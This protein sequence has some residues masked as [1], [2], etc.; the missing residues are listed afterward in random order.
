MNWSA[1]FNGFIPRAGRSAPVLPGGLSRTVHRVCNV[2]GPPGRGD[3]SLW[4]AEMAALAVYAAETPMSQSVVQT[5]AGDG[6]P[7]AALAAGTA[8][9]RRPAIWTLGSFSTAADA[10]SA[11]TPLFGALAA[12]GFGRQV[13]PVTASPVAAAQAWDGSPV[14]LLV[15][16]AG[17]GVAACM[18]AYS[19]WSRHLTDGARVILAGP[20]NTVA[21]R[22]HWGVSLEPLFGLGSLRVCMH[23]VPLTEGV[24]YRRAA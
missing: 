8:F 11:E 23:H 6:R 18:N 15:V 5:H 19:A 4:R 13:V 2:L 7:A 3:A 9:A 24:A 10:R 20:V 14:G 12:T 21:A 22:L 1:S 17:Q 16:D